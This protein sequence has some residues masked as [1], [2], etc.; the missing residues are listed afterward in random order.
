MAKNPS[1]KRRLQST[2]LCAIAARRDCCVLPV[3]RAVNCQQLPQ[4]LCRIPT[5]PRR[6]SLLRS[7]L[8]GL[9]HLCGRGSLA[10]SA[11]VE[12]APHRDHVT[13]FFFCVLKC[14]SR[15]GVPQEVRPVVWQPTPLSSGS[16]CPPLPGDGVPLTHSP[17]GCSQR[18]RHTRGAQPATS[19]RRAV[20]V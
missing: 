12:V 4:Q 11:F 17:G 18:Y 15:S 5:A 3:R 20:A 9:P 8:L 14:R 1:L 6:H 19:G 13:S 7:G 10:G 16:L 2:F